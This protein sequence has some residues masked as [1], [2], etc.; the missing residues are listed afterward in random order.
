VFGVR[1][2]RIDH[3][4]QFVGTVDLAHIFVGDDAR[5]LRNPTL[6]QA[7]PI[8]EH[9]NGPSESRGGWIV[10]TGLRYPAREAE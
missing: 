4:E 5:T 7:P 3:E 6:F 1:P 2:D 10:P 9:H 8:P